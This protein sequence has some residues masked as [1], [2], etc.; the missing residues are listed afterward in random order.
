MYAV[1]VDVAS[2][3]NRIAGRSARGMPVH[4]DPHTNNTP[5]DRIQIFKI[6]FGRTY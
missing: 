5:S 3:N 1:P 2:A 6:S 4:I